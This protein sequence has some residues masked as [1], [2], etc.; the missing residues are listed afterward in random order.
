MDYDLDLTLFCVRRHLVQ[1]FNC[2]GLPSIMIVAAWIL[3]LKR[4]L[5]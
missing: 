4:R 1:R 3:G 5:V 2:L